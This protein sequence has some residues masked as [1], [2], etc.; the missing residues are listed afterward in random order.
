MLMI[1]AELGDDRLPPP[2]CP[3][4]LLL[5]HCEFAGE[6]R[7]YFADRPHRSLAGSGSACSVQPSLLDLPDHLHAVWTL[8]LIRRQR[9]EKSSGLYPL[10]WMA[11]RR[12]CHLANP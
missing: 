6:T 11:A 8:L 5:L 9:F 10:D 1:E 3:R 2:P 4:R 12:I 7:Q